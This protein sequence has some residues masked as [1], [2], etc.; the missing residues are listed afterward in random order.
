MEKWHVLVLV[1]VHHRF[2]GRGGVMS[3]IV[4]TKIVALSHKIEK[5]YYISDSD[6]LLIDC[7]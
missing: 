5:N 6:L 2:D 1:P 4:L 3:Y 7:Q